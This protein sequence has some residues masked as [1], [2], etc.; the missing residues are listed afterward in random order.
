MSE[1]AAHRGGCE[2]A[3]RGPTEH[4]LAKPALAVGAGDDQVGAVLLR[5]P[6]QSARHVVIGLSEDLR[7]GTITQIN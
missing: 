3:S 4:P 6:D 7:F 2:Q 1:E 5:H